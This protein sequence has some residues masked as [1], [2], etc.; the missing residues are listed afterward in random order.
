LWFLF[1]ILILA[2]YQTNRLSEIFF[3]T[4]FHIYMDPSL[5]DQILCQQN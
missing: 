4:L 2:N 1:S 5:M 3:N